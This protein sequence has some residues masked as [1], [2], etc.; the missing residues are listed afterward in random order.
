MAVP[1]IA[2]EDLKKLLES[3]ETGRPVIIDVRLKYPYEHSTLRIPGSMRVSPKEP[4]Y[5][6]V[7]KGRDVVAYDSDPNELVSSRIAGDLI[8]LGY[9]AAALKGG[10]NEWISANFPTE[11]KEGVRQSAPAPGSLKA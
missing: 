10:I 8:R 5:A 4:D 11:N 6:H 1:R 7:P 9:K 3:E 2:K